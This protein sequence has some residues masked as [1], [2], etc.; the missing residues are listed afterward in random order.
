MRLAMARVAYSFVVMALAMIIF[1]ASSSFGASKEVDLGKVLFLEGGQHGN[2]RDSKADHQKVIFSEEDVAASVSVLLGVPPPVMISSDSSAKLDSVLSPSPFQRPGSVLALTIRGINLELLSAGEKKAIF[3]QSTTQ[4]RLLSGSTRQEP[5]VL[6]G[7]EVNIE[8][9][10]KNWVDQEEVEQGLEAMMTF[11]GGVFK[12]N[13]DVVELTVTL[14]ESVSISLDLSKRAHREFAVELMS[15]SHFTKRAATS[16]DSRGTAQLFMDTF[17]GVEAMDNNLEASKIFLFAVAQVLDRGQFVGVFV[18]P[19]STSVNESEQEIFQVKFP[20]RSRSLDESSP[21]L[22][23]SS[24]NG[25]LSK[26]DNTL[27]ELEILYLVRSSLVVATTII[28]L[29]ATLLGTCYLVGMPLT[30]DTL[31]YSG[32]K[33]D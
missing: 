24:S 6:S 14:E 32:V 26:V 3:G 12:K 4:Q 31:L 9:L 27:I 20:I 16:Q 1:S 30:R 19:P 10:N 22:G 25:D 5:F 21:S 17:S 33:L 23:A 15:L 8:S 11:L 29:I 28:L 18:F 13:G 7:Q 2:L